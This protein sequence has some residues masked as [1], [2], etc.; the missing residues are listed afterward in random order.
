M[1]ESWDQLDSL[2]LMWF[3]LAEVSGNRPSMT[4]CLSVLF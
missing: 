2:A 1:G 3:R 4:Q